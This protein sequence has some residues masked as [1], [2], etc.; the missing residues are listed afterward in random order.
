MPKRPPS[1]CLEPGCPELTT[2]TR[3]AKH[4]AQVA[5]QW[6][7]QRGTARQRGYD[8]RW[9]NLARRYIRQHPTCELCGEHPAKEVDHIIALRDG[10]Q[11]YAT[12]NMQALCRPCH[13]R[14]T[15]QEKTRR[16][17]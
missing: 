9:N 11:K 6:D 4:E 8:A 3:C 10:G 1:P 12:Y 17:G 7:R 14:K 13:R 2:R 15:A 16:R 5:R